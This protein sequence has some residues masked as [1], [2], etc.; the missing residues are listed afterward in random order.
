MDRFRATQYSTQEV[1]VNCR[2]LFVFR[3]LENSFDCYAEAV[4]QFGA[5]TPL[6]CNLV[7]LLVCELSFL[8]RV[9]SHS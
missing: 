8:P 5:S 1:S 4:G 9:V 2:D 3:V 7:L 6:P